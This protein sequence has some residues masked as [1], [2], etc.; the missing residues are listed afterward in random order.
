MSELHVQACQKLNAAFQCCIV[1]PGMIGMG[2]N[3]CLS[4][5]DTICKYLIA[6]AELRCVP[7]M[8]GTSFSV[9]AVEDVAAAVCE[10]PCTS[11]SVLAV[12][13]FG[14]SE[15]E[16]AT[17]TSAAVTIFGDVAEVALSDFVRTIASRPNALTPLLSYFKG[18]G[19]PLGID[20]GESCKR[21]RVTRIGRD[22]VVRAFEWL[23]S[24]GLWPA[25]Q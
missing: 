3:G 9:C 14:P 15:I 10:T 5:G 19:F 17:V 18:G 13:V 23:K 12:N 25:P 24:R 11:G 21:S 6:L 4:P 8:R 1:R 16:V 2:Q 20:T 7:L 22:D